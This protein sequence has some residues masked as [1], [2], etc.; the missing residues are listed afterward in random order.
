MNK[1]EQL[2][3]YIE[4]MHNMMIATMLTVSVILGVFGWFFTKNWALAV[5]C[6]VAVWAYPAFD[7]IRRRVRRSRKE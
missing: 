7:N 3:D 4:S 2:Y 1:S 5:L 6:Y